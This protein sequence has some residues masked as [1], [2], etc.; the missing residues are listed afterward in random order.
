MATKK[1]AK[2]ATVKNPFRQRVKP[3]V[4]L[5]LAY[6]SITEVDAEVL[7][8]GLFEG[9]ENLSRAAREVDARMEGAITEICQRRMFTG[10]A[11][12]IFI[13][14]ATRHNVRANLVVCAGMG[15]FDVF[16]PKVLQIVAENVAR[17]LVGAKVGDF[18][19]VLFGATRGNLYSGLTNL[20]DGFLRGVRGTQARNTL[21]SITVCE[22]NRL[23]C[24]KI[25]D[26]LVRLHRTKRSR[27]IDV[28]LEKIT[29][30]PFTA[31]DHGRAR[32]PVVIQTTQVT[33]PRKGQTGIRF[34]VLGAGSKATVLSKTKT[35]KVS[36]LDELVAEVDGEDFV[37][38]YS[39]AALKRYG[40][41]LA[42]AVVPTEIADVLQEAVGKRRIVMCQDAGTSRIPWETLCINGW[43][44]AAGG[45]MSRQYIA[46]HMPVARW[47][48]HRRFDETVDVLLIVNPT[49]DLDGA[50]LEGK[51]VKKAVSG[52]AGIKITELR[53]RAATKAR[54]KKELESGKY[55]VLHY[56]GH[57]SFYPDDPMESGIIC[58]GHRVL[59]GSE[60]STVHNLPAVVFF[61][62][63]ESA[64]VGSRTRRGAEGLARNIGLAETLLRGGV[65][66]YVGTHWVVEDL[67]APAFMKA[68]YGAL[69]NGQSMGDAIS[70]GRHAV[71]K[72]KSR[73]WADYIHYGSPNFLLK[74]PHGKT[75]R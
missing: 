31:A 75:A 46:D 58:A 10:K 64:R 14:P 60:L 70:N 11:G 43:F 67:A 26:A 18:A 4:D 36:E 63:C 37:N 38:D 41:K 56:A 22:T 12:E 30:P 57:T 48:E 34:S 19:T 6:G 7:V 68:F 17:T 1:R 16:E 50:E 44:P 51:I 47:L 5:R 32:T 28:T 29:L 39:T 13:L 74:V 45:G 61:N 54:V 59:S 53:R 40:K 52:L 49:G 20:V 42:K 69:L 27:D 25:E 72:L 71:R 73:D 66:N 2:A 23:R 65:A 55:D 21:R 62:S 35:I 33:S 9:I 15:P 24:Q 3:R 8:L